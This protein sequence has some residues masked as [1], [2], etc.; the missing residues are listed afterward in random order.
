MNEEGFV[1]HMKITDSEVI[2]LGVQAQQPLTGDPMY[3]TFSDSLKMHKFPFVF[4]ES[5]SDIGNSYNREHI[6]AFEDIIPPD[7]Y[8]IVS[9]LYDTISFEIDYSINSEFDEYGTMVFNGQDNLNGSFEFLR[10]KRL[11]VTHIDVLLR[12]R[13]SGNYTPLGDTPFA[14]Q[15]PME[16]PM[17]DS[18]FSLNYWTKDY[19]YP[20][21]EIFTDNSYT[22]VIQVNYRYCDKSFVSSNLYTVHRVYPN[23]AINSVNFVFDNLAERL[24]YV[25]SETGVLVDVLHTNSNH[26]EFNTEELSQGNYLYKITDKNGIY[27][28]SGRFLILNK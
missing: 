22:N 20:L 28:S 25:Y 16:L 7:Y 4:G 8:G 26:I 10:E 3:L 17:I 12:S 24:I 11:Y 5:H 18:I 9:A 14:D 1:I 2:T 23:P 6:S 15:L 19:K 13:N 21:A 27:L